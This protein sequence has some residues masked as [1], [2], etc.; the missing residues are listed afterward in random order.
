MTDLTKLC[1]KLPK[2]QM[3]LVSTCFHGT[4]NDTW[5]ADLKLSMVSV[6]LDSTFMTTTLD[7]CGAGH[8]D[9]HARADGPWYAGL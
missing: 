4:R 8:E 6:D 9:G 3:L 7:N 5:S 1:Q 2:L